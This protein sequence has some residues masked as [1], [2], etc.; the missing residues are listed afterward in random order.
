[1]DTYRASNLRQSLNLRKAL[2]GCM[3][4]TT[5]LVGVGIGVPSVASTKVVA[6][7][8]ADWAWIDT[9]HTPLSPTLLADL[10]RLNSLLN[11]TLARTGADDNAGAGY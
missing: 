11:L 8:S 9:E 3:Q 7:T 1:M 10:V 5:A 4:N 2:K 6:V